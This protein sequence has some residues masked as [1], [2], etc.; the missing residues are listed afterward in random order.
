MNFPLKSLLG[1]NA[2]D[3]FSNPRLSLQFRISQ[4]KYI[5]SWRKI[6][7]EITAANGQLV[8][9]CQAPLSASQ[10]ISKKLAPNF[11]IIFDHYEH[12]ASFFRVAGYGNSL[13][14]GDDITAVLVD[15]EG[16][17]VQYWDN[18]P[19][20]KVFL[21]TV[22]AWNDLRKSKNESQVRRKPFRRGALDELSEEST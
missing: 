22:F 13:P 3:H 9:V 7:A 11:P 16:R 12:I 19:M 10:A 4:Q 1:A 20:P 2:I 8:V 15:S 18:S 17:V 6:S 5:R 21:P 14:T